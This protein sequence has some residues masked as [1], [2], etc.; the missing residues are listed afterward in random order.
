M[1]KKNMV[2]VGEF[3]DWKD[4]SSVFQDIY[5]WAE[6]EFNLASP[7]AAEVVYS[8]RVTPDAYRIL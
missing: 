7:G 1:A 2:T 5:A 8:L 6:T 3:Y 4:N